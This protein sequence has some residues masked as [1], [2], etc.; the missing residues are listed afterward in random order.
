MSELVHQIGEL[1][2]RAVPVALIVL[3]F[4]F[5]LRFLFF[6]PLLKVMAEREARTIGAKKAAEAAQAAAAEKIKQYQEALRQAH[7]KVYAE[8]EVE[9]KKILDERA[10]LLKQARAKAAT[11]V[12]SAKDRIAAEAVAAKKELEAVIAQIAGEI[13]QRVLQAS[14]SPGSPSPGGP[15]RGAR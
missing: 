4:Y 3:I 14:P 6:K 8:Q 13:A 9:R 7:A 12:A 5:V 1:F 11:E 15:S 10:D 2:L